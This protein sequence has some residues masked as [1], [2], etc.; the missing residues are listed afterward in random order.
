MGRDTGYQHLSDFLSLGIKPREDIEGISSCPNLGAGRHTYNLL[1]H[2][3]HPTKQLRMPENPSFWCP[4]SLLQ[5]WGRTLHHCIS[6]HQL[7]P[8]LSGCVTQESSSDWAWASP[9]CSNPTTNTPQT[10]FPPGIPPSLC[11]QEPVPAELLPCRTFP[12]TPSVMEKLISAQNSS[13]GFKSDD[14]RFFSWRD[15]GGFQ[16]QQPARCDPCFPGACV[17]AHT[18]LQGT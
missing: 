4:A 2:S 8:R 18:S 1:C 7:K 9:Q 6:S 5:G 14:H 3:Q 12:N 11:H 10:L 13:K 17:Q 16:N 15:V